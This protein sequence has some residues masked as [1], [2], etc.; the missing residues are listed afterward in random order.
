[1]TIISTGKIIDFVS[2]ALQLKCSDP[3][4]LNSSIYQITSYILDPCWT[5]GDGVG[6]T[7]KRL[8]VAANRDECKTMVITSEPS[9]NGATFVNSDGPGGCYAEFDMSRVSVN[10]NWQTCYFPGKL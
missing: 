6:G 9:A 5:L 1:M 2:K 7:E 10:S 4:S 8:G 3:F